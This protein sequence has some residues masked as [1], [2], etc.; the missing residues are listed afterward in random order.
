MS[1]HDEDPRCLWNGSDQPRVLRHRHLEDCENP[2]DCRGCQ[3]CTRAHCLV[4]YR[5]H[6]ATVCAECVGTTRDNLTQI[7][8]LYTH[9]PAEAQTRGYTGDRPGTVLG[10][11]AMV[12]LAM[13]YGDQDGTQAPDHTHERVTDPQPPLVVL[14]SWEDTYRTTLA[15]PRN[16]TPEVGP[17]ITWLE[18][19]LTQLAATSQIPF[20]EFAD[21]IRDLRHHLENVL[22]DGDRDEHADDNIEC[23][24]CGATPRKRMLDKGIEDA[25][26]C[27][28]CHRH[29]APHEFYLAA[30]H[31][32]QLTARTLLEATVVETRDET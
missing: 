6:A 31:A 9:L 13:T 22:H 11:D 30:A 3:P 7:W 25:W 24:T 32:A 19:N 8:T 14:A 17:T 18:D 16:E 15:L 4:C 29:L 1:D 12:M 28:G 21:E 26:W 5:E 10:G 23:L 27:P 20:A 2:S